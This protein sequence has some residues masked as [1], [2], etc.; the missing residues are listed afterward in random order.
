MSWTSTLRSLGGALGVLQPYVAPVGEQLGLAVF[1]EAKRAATLANLHRRPRPLRPS[2]VARLQ[3]LFADLD[4]TTVR[5]RTRCRLPANRF[6]GS[7]SIYAMTFGTTI[8]FRDEL[9]EDAPRDVVHLLHELV[10]VDQAR[11]LGGERSFAC[12]YGEGYLDGGGALP[13]YMDEVTAYHRNPL[14]AE[15]YAF[16]A[17]FRDARGRIVAALLPRVTPRP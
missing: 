16:E 7:G 6:R 2:T 4:L 17:R 8:F 1:R 12:A 10:H 9:D 13:S 15:A 3:P 14:E 11:R 5:V